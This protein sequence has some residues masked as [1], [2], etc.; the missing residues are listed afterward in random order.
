MPA[1]DSSRD[2]RRLMCTM[3]LAMGAAAWLAACVPAVEVK[4]ETVAAPAPVVAEALPG[5]IALAPQLTGP[6]P[7]AGAP[8]PTAAT[9]AAVLA[10]PAPA[11]VETRAVPAA[12]LATAQVAAPAPPPVTCPS[13]TVGMWSGPDVAGA[14]VYICRRLNPRL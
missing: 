8:E 1:G 12:T 7:A 11:Q 14:S 4:S 5:P 6:P 13:D 3:A 10:A 2:C 9:I